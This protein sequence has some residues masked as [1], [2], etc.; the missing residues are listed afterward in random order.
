MPVDFCED[1]STGATIDNPYNCAS[2]FICENG[3][4]WLMW[5]P[6]G[7]LWHSERHRCEYP[8]LVDCG[9][10]PTFTTPPSTTTEALPTTA[11]PGHPTTQPA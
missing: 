10:R 9:S 6:G 2:F 8:D 5:C 7:L 4:A 3:T 11:E 1:Q